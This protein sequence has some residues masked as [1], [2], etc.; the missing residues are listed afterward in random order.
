MI[1]IG[2]QPIGPGRA[3]AMVA[4]VARKGRMALK[5]FIALLGLKMYRSV[6]TQL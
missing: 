5:D 4:I 3:D 1:G 6:D 2:S